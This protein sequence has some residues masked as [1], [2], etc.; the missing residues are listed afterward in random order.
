MRASE[1]DDEVGFT[2]AFNSF[3]TQWGIER[4]ARK[5]LSVTGVLLR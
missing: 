5:V 1:S 4:I 2:E 3:A